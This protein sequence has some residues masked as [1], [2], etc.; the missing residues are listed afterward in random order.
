MNLR[1]LLRDRRLW[2]ALAVVAAIALLRATG[3]AD[4]LSIDTLAKHR[5]GLA[6]LVEGDRPLAMLGFVAV[7]VAAVALSLPG[8]FVI[9]LTGGFLF[10]AVAGTLL[11]VLGATIGACI[12]FALARR[13]FG[14]DGLDRL[15]PQ[16]ARL[17]V[18]I[19]RDAGP[20]LLAVRLAPLFPFFLVN[21]VTA[22]VGVPF[23]IFLPTTALG[24]LPG[25][26]VYALTGGGLGRVLDAGGTPDLRSVLTP[27]I[28][29]ALFGLAALSLL[30]IP[31]RRRFA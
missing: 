13:V 24:I 3:L 28:L 7:Y 5:A 12:V 22:L 20:L 17:A 11:S 14:S 18:A 31:L 16:A 27:E 8:A 26:A 21:L 9:T 23:R 10:G 30:A 6:A 15:G 19:R 29:G 1:P 2:L 4:L 25:S